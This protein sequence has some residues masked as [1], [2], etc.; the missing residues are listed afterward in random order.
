LPFSPHAVIGALLFNWYSAFFYTFIGS[1]L[2][3][4]LMF[5]LT[6]TLAKDYILLLSKKYK[7]LKKYEIREEKN[8]FND[9][10]MLRM[11]YL[12]P[13]EFV[14]IISGLSNVKFKK[15]FLATMLGNIPMI[16]FTTIFI[17]AQLAKNFGH[18]VFAIIGLVSLLIIPV[19]YFYK[20]KK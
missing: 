8:Y 5:F 10:L 1:T 19:I 2:F 9:I 3:T 15:Y 4:S 12:I 13:S 11:F 17:R 7:N 14:S 18:L 16:F 6:R 20:R